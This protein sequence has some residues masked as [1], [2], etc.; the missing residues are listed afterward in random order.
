MAK[1]RRKKKT[2]IELAR[3]ELERL[4]AEQE[5]ADEDGEWEERED[6]DE[7]GEEDD[8]SYELEAVEENPGT[9]LLQRLVG[10]LGAMGR[11]VFVE[12]E[13]PE[14][15]DGNSFKF[16]RRTGGVKRVIYGPDGKPKEIVVEPE[17]WPPR[18]EGF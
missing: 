13:T 12:E 9:G 8:E 18:N 17:E 2:R 4:E 3:E 6:E 11:S 16:Q 5:A 15:K 7:D 10:D 14:D 1:K